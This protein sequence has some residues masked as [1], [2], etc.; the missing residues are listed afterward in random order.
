MNFVGLF[1]RKWSLVMCKN[2]IKPWDR[3][4]RIMSRLWAWI[5]LEWID[6]SQITEMA[7]HKL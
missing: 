6:T 1:E 4:F 3:D 2:A 7:A 5:I